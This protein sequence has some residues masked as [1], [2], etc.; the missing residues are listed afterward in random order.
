MGVRHHVLGLRSQNSSQAVSAN[1]PSCPAGCQMARHR[2]PRTLSRRPQRRKSSTRRRWRSMRGGAT[3]QCNRRRSRRPAH[4][5]SMASSC[6][7]DPNLLARSRSRRGCRRCQQRLCACD[8]RRGSAPALRPTP[9][10]GGA[11]PTCARIDTYRRSRTC[12]CSCSRRTSE[13]G[14]SPAGHAI[15]WRHVRRCSSARACN[16]L[17]RSTCTTGSSPTCRW[18]PRLPPGPG[19]RQTSRH[20]R[21]TRSKA[22]SP[23]W[24]CR[25][26]PACPAILLPMAHLW[27]TP[28]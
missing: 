11:P 4:P 15:A 7:S 1:S 6:T 26:S 23:N 13:C 28:E 8:G 5:L 16:G 10:P 14:T 9:R 19:N 22:C 21:W 12:R 2:H 17:S 27:T 24:A 20:H 3:S 25:T 18:R